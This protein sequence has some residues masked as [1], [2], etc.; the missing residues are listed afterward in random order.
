MIH[1]KVLMIKRR[2][3]TASTSPSSGGLLPHSVHGGSDQRRALYPATALEGTSEGDL[4]GILEV[5]TN[6]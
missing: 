2:V 4:V 1:E 5:A 6:R 3:L